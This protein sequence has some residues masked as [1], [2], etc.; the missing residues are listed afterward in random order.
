MGGD[1]NVVRFAWERTGNVS[2][3][4]EMEVFSEFINSL[5]LVD[6]PLAGGSFTW[7][8]LRDKLSQSRL[9]QY[10]MSLECL[11]CWPDVRQIR[12]PKNISDHNP[13]VLRCQAISGGPRPFRFFDHWLEQKDYVGIICDTCSSQRDIEIGKLLS[14]CQSRSRDWVRKT[15][16]NETSELGRLENRQAELENEVARGINAVSYHDELR[17]I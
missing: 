4:R 3:K 17:S 7:S 1:F 10:L 12:L 14:C 11:E 9:D 8:S 16:D 13:I 15:K 5:N 2:S 6:L